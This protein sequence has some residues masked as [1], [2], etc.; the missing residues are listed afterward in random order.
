MAFG[1]MSRTLADSLPFG[2]VIC[3]IL[4]ITAAFAVAPAFILRP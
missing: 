3:V 4:D 2:R 1:D